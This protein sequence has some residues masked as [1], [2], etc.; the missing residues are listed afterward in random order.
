MAWRLGIASWE[1]SG[2]KRSLSPGI[3][4]SAQITPDGSL[5]AS[6]SVVTTDAGGLL[7]DLI[8]GGATRGGNFLHRFPEFNLVFLNSIKERRVPIY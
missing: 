3:A 6:G 8:S 2:A 7:V 4:Q 1:R 5:G